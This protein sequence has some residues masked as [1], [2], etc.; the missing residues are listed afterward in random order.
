MHIDSPP[1]PPP[2]SRVTCSKQISVSYTT[3]LKEK[4]ATP[5]P[6]DIQAVSGV[7][8]DYTSQTALLGATT[9]EKSHDL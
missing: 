6:Q 9:S 1:P 3:H 7:K 2:W 4:T 5:L 8:T